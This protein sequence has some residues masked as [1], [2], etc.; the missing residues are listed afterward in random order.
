MNRLLQMR[1]KEKKMEI[2]ISFLST[3][4]L[5]NRIIFEINLESPFDYIPNCSTN[6]MRFS[7]LPLTSNTLPGI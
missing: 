5:Q 3:W 4:R 1:S 2:E 7:V 6:E